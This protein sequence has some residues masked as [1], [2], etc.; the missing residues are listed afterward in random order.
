MKPLVASLVCLAFCAGV[1][2]AD[3]VVPV[4]TIRA[5]ETILAGDLKTTPGEVSGGF[6]KISDVAGLEARVALYPGRPVRPDDVTQPALIERNQMTELVF[7]RAGLR[8]ATEA[9]ALDRAG[10][11]DL[12]KVMNMASHSTVYGRVLADGTISVSQ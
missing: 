6:S 7:E 12:I 10:V 11:G 5:Q 3:S 9:R 1:S 4:R 2:R 8:I